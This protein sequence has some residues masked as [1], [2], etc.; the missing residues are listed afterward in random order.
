MCTVRHTDLASS[1]AGDAIPYVKT[2]NNILCQSFDY[3]DNSAVHSAG[4][5]AIQTLVQEKGKLLALCST[6]WLST[7]RSVDRLKACFVSVV[8]SLQREG[9]D[10]MPKLLV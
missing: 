3:F 7:D 9:E 6:R 2:F 4:L 5:Q 1:Q 10:Q 8:L